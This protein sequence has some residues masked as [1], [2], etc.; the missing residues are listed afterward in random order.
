MTDAAMIVPSLQ[1]DAWVQRMADIAFACAVTGAAE[2]AALIADL[3]HALARHPQGR[4]TDHTEQLAQLLA[5]RADVTAVLVLV[6]PL[7]SYMLSAAPGAAHLATVVARGASM[8]HHA[9]GN[10]A[11]LALAGALASALAGSAIAVDS[12]AKGGGRG[13]FQFN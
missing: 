11:A 1:I 7:A 13:A 4:F 2:G 6:E 10:S 12:L 9:E 3:A 8:E 5:A